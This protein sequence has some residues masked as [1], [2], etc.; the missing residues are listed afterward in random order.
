M[1]FTKKKTKTRFS[2]RSPKRPAARRARRDAAYFKRD[3][4]PV[5]AADTTRAGGERFEARPRDA[6]ET[7]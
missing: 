3:M 1:R 4:L 6:V 7:P 2:R 5:Y